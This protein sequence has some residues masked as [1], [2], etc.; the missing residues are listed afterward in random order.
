MQDKAGP[1]PPAPSPKHP[2]GEG[3]KPVRFGHQC[4]LARRAH[5][6][7]HA[8]AKGYPVVKFLKQRKMDRY[9]E[10]LRWGR[11]ALSVLR[12]TMRFLN[13]RG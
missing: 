1:Q 8:A 11:F 6:A 13:T 7:K 9:N 2:V 5:R 12:I 4:L 10:F 3:E